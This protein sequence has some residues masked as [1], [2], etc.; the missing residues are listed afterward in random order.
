MA[1][2]SLEI[3]N[4]SVLA[5]DCVQTNHTLYTS[6]LGKRRVGRLRRAYR[7]G[8]LHVTA[9]PDTLWGDGLGSFHLRGGRGGRGG[10]GNRSDEAA[11][12]AAGD[13]TG[14]AA[15]NATDHALHA[16]GCRQLFF[17]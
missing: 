8:R 11:D 7:H 10:G 13:A 14:H 1:A 5:D 6:L 12:Y 9:N 15:R 17:L 3:L 2:G 4:G 16:G